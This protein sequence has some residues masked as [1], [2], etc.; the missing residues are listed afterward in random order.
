MTILDFRC[1]RIGISDFEM[2]TLISV[3]YLMLG[4]NNLSLTKIKLVIEPLCK[5]RNKLIHYA[6]VLS[7]SE[8]YV[9][10]FGQLE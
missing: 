7:G 9:V 4:I 3:Y 2:I 5:H 1:F 10:V 6:L 8:L